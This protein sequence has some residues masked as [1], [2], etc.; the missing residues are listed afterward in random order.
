[1]FLR[2]D[3]PQCAL[4]LKAFSVERS[5]R[6]VCSGSTHF[7]SPLL[8]QLVGNSFSTFSQLTVSSVCLRAPKNTFPAHSFLRLCTHSFSVFKSL[9]HPPTPSFSIPSSL[10]SPLFSWSLHSTPP[11]QTAHKRAE[12]TTPDLWQKFQSFSPFLSQSPLSFQ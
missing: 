12:S 7:N 9:S 8:V 11:L 10:S 2:I 1:M 3:P 5:L 6:V 4:A